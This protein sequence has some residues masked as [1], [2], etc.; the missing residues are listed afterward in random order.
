MFTTLFNHGVWCLIAN[1]SI[2]L[3]LMWGS[4]I[5]N[6]PRFIV[7]YLK[8][9]FIC[10]LVQKPHENIEYSVNWLVLLKCWSFPYRL[11]TSCSG[12]KPYVYIHV[13]SSIGLGNDS[14]PFST[15]HFLNPCWCM[16]PKNP[17]DNISRMCYKI[18]SFS[19]I[20]I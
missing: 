2:A 1:K 6:S 3:V 16:I 10:V 18:Y 5:S 8:C 15:R 9:L 11:R 4:Q 19:Q 14:S 13:D 7:V 12:Q 20:G 17:K